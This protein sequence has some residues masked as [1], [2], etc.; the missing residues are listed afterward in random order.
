[1]EMKGPMGHALANQKNEK[2]NKPDIHQSDSV[3]DKKEDANGK[4]GGYPAEFIDLS[5]PK[6][7]LKEST[8]GLKDSTQTTPRKKSSKDTLSESTNKTIS[9]SRKT[10][11]GIKSPRDRP[12]SE[13]LSK[14]DVKGLTEESTERPLEKSNSKTLINRKNPSMASSP[15]KMNNEEIRGSVSKASKIEEKLNA[16]KGND[17]KKRH[18]KA[19]D[20]DNQKSDKNSNNSEEHQQQQ[21]PHHHHHHH[22]HEDHKEES[23]KHHKHHEET[24]KE[25]NDEAD[26][27]R[28]KMRK[29]AKKN[30]S[31]PEEKS[32]A[33]TDLSSNESKQ[34]DQNTPNN[35]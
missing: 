31:I 27:N 35:S 24:K 7:S 14:I 18:T 23:K 32:L 22:H 21:Q 5:K 29:K 6:P 9:T 15:R 33:G 16:E 25:T 1:M 30:T 10:R 4:K 17:E 11:D 19:A 3:E 26:N 13:R 28:Y 12:E 34:L 2:P 20:P 8:K